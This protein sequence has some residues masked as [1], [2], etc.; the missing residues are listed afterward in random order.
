MAKTDGGFRNYL[1]N[2]AGML[3]LLFMVCGFILVLNTL[4][5]LVVSPESAT[6]VIVMLNFTG[7]IPLVAGIG[8]MVLYCRNV[9]A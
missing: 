1:C 3:Q 8:Y 4:S 6:Y 5:L 9:P 7:L 2:Y